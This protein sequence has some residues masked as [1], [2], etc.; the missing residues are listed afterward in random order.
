[1]ELL[2]D[3]FFMDFDLLITI[4]G[5]RLCVGFVDRFLLRLFHWFVA[6]TSTWCVRISLSNSGFLHASFYN[7]L[8][9][10]SDKLYCNS[11]CIEGTKLA[12][13]SKPFS[14]I[15]N[16]YILIIKIIV[17]KPKSFLLNLVGNI[18]KLECAMG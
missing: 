7:I 1:M 13:P 8:I 11:H 18:I 10:M 15:T 14:I 17:K 2:T 16:V 6:P 4:L 9:F 3:G 12:F 5:T